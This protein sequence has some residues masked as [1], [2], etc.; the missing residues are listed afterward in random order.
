MI[1]I[2]VILLETAEISML[3]KAKKKEKNMLLKDGMSF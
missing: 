1:S 2:R 3:C